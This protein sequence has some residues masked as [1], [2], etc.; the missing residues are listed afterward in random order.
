[1]A[2][3]RRVTLT[4]G[5]GVVVVAVAGSLVGLMLSRRFA[6]RVAGRVTADGTSV[7]TFASPVKDCA[8]GH[9]F[10]PGFFGADLRSGTGEL[11][12]V[13]DSGDGARLWLYPPAPGQG[14]LGIGKADCSRWDVLVDWTHVTVNRVKTVSGHV[15]VDCAAG[16]GKVTA[17]VDFERCAL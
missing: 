17:D 8:S 4:F 12:R 5:I 9:A 11:L 15:R 3:N 14:P 1:M 13:V 6:E 7:G 10:V 16:G 2:D